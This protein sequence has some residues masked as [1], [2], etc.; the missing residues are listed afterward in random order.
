MPGTGALEEV[1]WLRMKL[2]RIEGALKAGANKGGAVSRLLSR[3]AT[4]TKE[5][6]LLAPT[7]PGGAAIQMCAFLT[8][9]PLLLLLLLLSAECRLRV[10]KGSQL[11]STAQ[12]GWLSWQRKAA[13]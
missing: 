4:T 11:G 8:R 9:L 10:P 13:G 5:S 6:F 12:P 1:D 2:E 7:A 3:Q